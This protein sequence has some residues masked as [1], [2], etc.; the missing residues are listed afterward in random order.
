MAS[1]LERMATELA[2]GA[3]ADN[4]QR[5]L[6]ET[7]RLAN[8]VANVDQALVEAEESRRLNVRALGTMD[9]APNLRS[10]LDAL[11]HCTVALRGLCRAVVDQLR[12]LPDIADRM[13]SPDTREVFAVLLRDLA[14]AVEAFGRLVRAEAEGGNSPDAELAIAL[15]AVG[16]ARVRLTE[17]LMIDPRDAPELW[18]LNGSVL[19]N[20]ERILRE[21]DL[22]ERARQRERRQREWEA[23]PSGCPSGRPASSHLPRGRAATVALAPTYG[24][25]ARRLDHPVPRRQKAAGTGAGDVPLSHICARCTE[26]VGGHRHHES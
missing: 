2:D 23:R 26:I 22:D 19:T 18:E 15:D 24:E 16:E 10:G 9:A 12:T 11:E 5:W 7:R 13:Y 3:S 6:E 8:R 20:V 21:I 17:L 4:A 14:A 1:L 25:Q